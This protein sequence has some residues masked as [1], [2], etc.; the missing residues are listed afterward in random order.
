[1]VFDYVSEAQLVVFKQVTFSV[2][3]KPWV[4]V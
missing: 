4:F 3:S 1:M 2:Y